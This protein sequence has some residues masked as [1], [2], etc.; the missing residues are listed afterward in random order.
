MFVSFLLACSFI[1]SFAIHFLNYD[2]FIL[3]F[4]PCPFIFL[5]FSFSKPFVISNPWLWIF[6][7]FP[8]LYLSILFLLLGTLITLFLSISHAN[9]LFCF[10]LYPLFPILLHHFSFPFLSFSILGIIVNLLFYLWLSCPLFYITFIRFFLILSN[11]SVVLFFPFVSS[12]CCLYFSHLFC[13]LIGPLILL[14]CP[15]ISC[16]PMLIILWWPLLLLFSYLNFFCILTYLMSFVVSPVYSFLTVILFVSLLLLF[17][18]L[19]H[20]SPVSY[21]VLLFSLSYCFLSLLSSFFLL[22]SSVLHFDFSLVSLV[23]LILGLF[24]SIFLWLV[25]SVLLV[26]YYAFVVT[27]SSHLFLLTLFIPLALCFGFLSYPLLF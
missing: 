6:A 27:V 13:W 9:L 19:W 1:L 8:Y 15:S 24:P 25:Y 10:L 12:T 16:S 18:F 20:L 21:P 23:S 17:F 4:S 26:C 5:P 11:L 14:C 2:L 3:C 7:P 22:F